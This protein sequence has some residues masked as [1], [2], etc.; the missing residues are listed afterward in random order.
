MQRRK[1]LIVEDDRHLREALADLLTA[2]GF[3]VAGVAD[4]E[5]ALQR[6]KASG[7]WLILLDFTLPK[8]SGQEILR[9]LQTNPRLSRDNQVIL[10]SSLL[11]RTKDRSLLSDLVVA[12][13]PK[14]FQWDELLETIDHVNKKG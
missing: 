9:Q 10:I 1:I 11:D 3:S 7:G 5:A 4:G 8:V 6:L 12:V 13:L 2:E 14:P